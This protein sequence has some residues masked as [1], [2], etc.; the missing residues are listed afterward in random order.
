MEDNSSP[1]YSKITCL[2]Q[3]IEI[4]NKK[5]VYRQT[6]VRKSTGSG[7]EWSVCS[8]IIET[9]HWVQVFYLDPRWLS[10]FVRGH[11]VCWRFGVWDP[12][13][14]SCIQQRKTICLPSI[15]KS[16]ACARAS[17]LITTNIYYMHSAKYDKSIV[18]Q[19]LKFDTLLG[20]VASFYALYLSFR[21]HFRIR[22]ME[23]V[24]KMFPI[25]D[26]I[27]ALMNVVILRLC[28]RLWPQQGL[29]LRHKPDILHDRP[30]I[31]PW[32]K[33]I[34]NELD[35]TIHMI[36]SQLSRY[37]DVICNRLWRHQLNEDRASETRGRC[38]NIVVFVII[39]GY[40]MSCKKWDYVISSQTVCAFTQVL[41]CVDFTC[42]FATRK[43]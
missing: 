35:T 16:L 34:S 9:G 8:L 21:K 41:F 38:V 22:V 1:V 4:N 10:R 37:C 18:M 27:V 31:S 30:W 20:I 43:K 6:Q 33:S 17:K 42:C 24:I 23:S 2:C 15:R 39:Y 3:S 12:G 11:S 5:Y 32:I 26:Q 7:V 28:N 13:F 29:L 36:A 40:I 19:N 25:L 14:E